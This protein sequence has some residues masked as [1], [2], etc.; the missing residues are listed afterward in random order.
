MRNLILPLLAAAV[1]A[2]Q[3]EVPQRVVSTAG[4]ASEVV[5]LLGKADVLV[6]VD[7]TSMRPLDVMEDKPKIGYRR[8]LS[9]EGILSLQPDLI[10]MAPDAGPPA[11]AEQIKASGVPLLALQDEQSLEGI[12]TDIAL[13][14]EALD[15]QAAGEELIA[16][17]LAD[18]TALAT[19]AAQYAGNSAL[20]LIDTG[21]QGV[22]GL[23]RNSA[24]AHL[25]EILQLEN[26][27]D[28]EGNKPLANE[29]LAASD[30]DVIFLASREGARKSITIE[31]LAAE[32]PQYAL[33]SN[34]AAGRKGCVFAVNILD[35]LGFSAYT[36]RYAAAMLKTA[37]P[38]L[39]TAATH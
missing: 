37:A 10:L 18:E 6:G 1:F 33:L 7:T 11:V 34:T 39:R 30:A 21:T 31:P 27:F 22:F 9:A 36:A 28:A 35:A 12:R 32:H 23:G 24:G 13:I 26:R 3:A 15:A 19:I 2:A 25:L 8:Q 20:V 17:I 14:A 4:N 38:C 16:E 29:A 5:A